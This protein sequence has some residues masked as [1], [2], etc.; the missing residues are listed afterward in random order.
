MQMAIQKRIFARTGKLAV[1]KFKRTNKNYNIYDVTKE[2]PKNTKPN[3]RFYR[4]TAVKKGT[5]PKSKLSKY[6][7]Y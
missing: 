7:K 3:E 2:V 4:I 5:F 1:R 6:D